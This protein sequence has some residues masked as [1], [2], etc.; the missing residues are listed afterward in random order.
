MNGYYE[1][2]QKPAKAVFA[3]DVMQISAGIA[4]EVSSGLLTWA[5]RLLQM[6]E[7]QWCPARQVMQQFKLV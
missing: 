1:N 7:R 6:A 2:A 3:K 5:A 4:S